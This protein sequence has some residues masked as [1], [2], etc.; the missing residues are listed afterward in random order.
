MK[1]DTRELLGTI[2]VYLGSA[3]SVAGVQAVGPGLPNLQNHFQLS[4]SHTLWAISF[5]LF[6]G[7]IFAVPLGK[8]ADRVG[9][10][11]T[12]GFCLLVF[13]L[14]SLIIPLAGFSW[15]LF[16]AIRILQGTAFA[17]IFPLSIILTAQH[18][19]GSSILKRQGFR[20]V[21][22]QI[23]DTAT[24]LIGGILVAAAWYAPYLV[25][26][27]TLPVAAVVFFLRFEDDYRVD[28]QDKSAEKL[29]ILGNL[30]L[31]SIIFGGFLKFFVKFVPLSSLGIMLVNQHGYS[32]VFAG[33]A[34]ALSSFV[35][36]FG[37]ISV[38]RLSK[39]LSPFT[40]SAS[41]L[42]FL[43]LS[44]LALS[45]TGNLVAILIAVSVFGF[46]DGLFGTV[47]NSYVAVAVPN[48]LRGTFSGVVAMSRNLGKFL[49]PIVMGLVLV[50]A[51][52]ST[53]FAVSG[54][55]AAL[56]MVLMPPLRHFNSQLK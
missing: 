30:P 19:K 52:I 2:S 10:M 20:S 26:I 29:K 24:P 53:A 49:A 31:I 48:H 17:G 36:I 21:T 34:L 37:A 40:I 14:A 15:P 33:F 25:G 12:Y 56:G 13:G 27:S 16:L 7:I 55:I 35:G 23:A 47:Q 38:G 32:A 43:S 1:A 44:L 5:Y 46:S 50:K 6:P 42:V 4:D 22:Q 8:L 9:R 45:A 3:F 54:I 18:A 28:R 41:T 51:S 11:K 39:Y